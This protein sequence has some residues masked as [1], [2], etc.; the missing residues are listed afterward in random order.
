MIIDVR[1]VKF[2][3]IIGR[4]KPYGEYPFLKKGKERTRYWRLLIGTNEVARKATGKQIYRP[5]NFLLE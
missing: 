4:I 3:G 1:L 2:G 5:I